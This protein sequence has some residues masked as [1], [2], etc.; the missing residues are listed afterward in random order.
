MSGDWYF[1][2]QVYRRKY[3]RLVRKYNRL[4]KRVGGSGDVNYT[5]WR[6]SFMWSA[7][8]K[9]KCKHYRLLFTEWRRRAKE[10]RSRRE[11]AEKR[12]AELEARNHKLMI[13]CNFAIGSIS[14][15]LATMHNV[16]PI[17]RTLTKTINKLEGALK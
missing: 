16:T 1:E 14:V 8:W 17:K 2:M 15:V 3:N 5:K 11:A 9:V 7:A 4:I 13:A 6:R 10:E 12:V